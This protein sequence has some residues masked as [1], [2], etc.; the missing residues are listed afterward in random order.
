MPKLNRLVAMLALSGAIYLPGCAVTPPYREVAT[1]TMATVVEI[2]EWDTCLN[3]PGAQTRPQRLA[4]TQARQQAAKAAMRDEE[5][6]TSMATATGTPEAAATVGVGAVE[7]IGVGITAGALA[8]VKGGDPVDMLAGA[9]LGAI[10]GAIAANQ[11]PEECYLKN[12]LTLRDDAG[13]S[14]HSWIRKTRDTKV[15]DTR[16]VQREMV[17]WL[18]FGVQGSEQ[19]KPGD[20]MYVVPTRGK[21]PEIR[22]IQYIAL[23]PTDFEAYRQAL[24]MYEKK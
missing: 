24:S 10:A 9:A 23:T 2:E 5:M 19:I 14:V 3:A 17:Y 6:A 4:Q 21:N 20:R 8:G 18:I 15:M 16:P 11:N 22:E 13:Q 12:R 1:P 7:G